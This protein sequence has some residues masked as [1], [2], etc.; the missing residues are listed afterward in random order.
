MVPEQLALVLDRNERDAGRVALQFPDSAVEP[1]GLAQ[2]C[3]V[4]LEDDKDFVA[5]R[6]NGTVPGR[7][8]VG[9]VDND[10][11]EAIG[12]LVQQLEHEIPSHRLKGQARPLERIDREPRLAGELDDVHKLDVEAVR[13]AYDAFAVE[14]VE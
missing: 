5:R 7:V 12:N 1:F 14:M 3:Y 9:Q 2:R 10:D 11:F 13:L 6:Q 8:A 4:E